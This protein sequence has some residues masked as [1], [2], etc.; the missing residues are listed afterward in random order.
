[1]VGRLEIQ[2][3][4]RTAEQRLG[5]R[6]ELRAFHDLILGAAPLPLDV[7]DQLVTEWLSGFR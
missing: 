7:L 1:M 4:R 3:M 5:R 6:F 2:R